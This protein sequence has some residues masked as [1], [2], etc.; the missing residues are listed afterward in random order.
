MTVPP[1]C[2]S[3]VRFS[4]LNLAL[5]CS[6]RSPVSALVRLAMRR[7]GLQEIQE[8]TNLTPGTALLLPCSSSTSLPE[9]PTPRTATPSRHQSP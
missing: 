6:R 5:L 4:A 7:M 2:S 3:V 1:H 9:Q 8:W